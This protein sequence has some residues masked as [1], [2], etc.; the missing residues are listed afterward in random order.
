MEDRDDLVEDEDVEDED[1]EEEGGVSPPPSKRMLPDR[2]DGSPPPSLLPTTNAAPTAAVV[3]KTH[4]PAAVAGVVEVPSMA[5]ATNI[6]ITSRGRIFK[7]FFT[8][9]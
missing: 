5:A 4:T 1:A 2:E 7:H 8:T 9:R 3:S 6:K